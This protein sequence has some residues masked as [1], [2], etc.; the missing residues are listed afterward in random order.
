MTTT[1]PI[2]VNHESAA[3]TPGRSR[4]FLWIGL[5]LACLLLALG[6]IPR[7]GRNH[8]AAATA[9]AADT[10]LAHVNVAKAVVASG[11]SELELPGN[12]EPINVAS[13]YART[14]GYLRERFVDIGSPVKTGQ[15]LAVIES[16]EVDQELAQA[17]ANLV[18]TRAALEQAKAN[19]QQ[20][21]AQVDQAQAN[22]AQARANQEIA[23]TTNE[24]WTRLVNN[25]VL[26]RQAGDE[27][28]STFEARRAETKA[29]SAAQTTAEANVG[30][31]QADI[32]AAEAAV[33]AQGANVRRLEQMQAFERLQAPFDGVVTERRVERGDLIAAGSGGDRPLFSV[34]QGRTLRI[35]VSVPQA[36]SVDIHNGQ[37]AQV[38]VRER[39]DERFEGVIA[40][41]AESI[42]AASRTLLTEVQVDNRSGRLLPGMYAQVKFTL[43]RSHPVVIVPGNCLVINAG[44]T[45]VVRL[46]EGDRV[47]YLPVQIGR[48]LGA[49]VEILS[50]LSGSETLVSNPADTLVENQ[51]VKVAGGGEPKK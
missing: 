31:R 16:P 19:V 1:Q 41:T 7:L 10:D 18:Q 15:V 47:R 5:V 38:I 34:A 50:G 27:R 2:E 4:L 30:A 25:G 39:P 6:I 20:A 43:P 46:A 35:Q 13:L 11:S 36:Y 37:K 40:R 28:R 33:Q 3:P 29:A 44:G 21:R 12:T 48:D 8:R 22:V 23:A 26:P 42:A 49:E 24:R 32:A 14:S 9:Q 45:R 51:Q 17:R